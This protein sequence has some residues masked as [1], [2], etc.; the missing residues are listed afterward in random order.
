MM[1]GNFCV[2]FCSREIIQER[3]NTIQ[4]AAVAKPSCGLS[5]RIAKTLPMTGEF[6]CPNG[7]D[8]LEKISQL[9]T[10]L[11]L[12]RFRLPVRHL[13]IAWRPLCPPSTN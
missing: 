7:Y 5:I 2:L 9:C 13:V 8:S 11:L 6:W 3:L 10:A 1:L 4:L 12:R